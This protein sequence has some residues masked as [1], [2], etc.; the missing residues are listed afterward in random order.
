MLGPSSGV[1]FGSWFGSRVNLSIKKRRKRRNSSRYFKRFADQ[2]ISSGWNC[3]PGAW[4]NGICESGGFLCLWLA[5]WAEFLDGF[6]LRNF[7][8]GNEAMGFFHGSKGVGFYV[9]NSR[10]DFDRCSGSGVRC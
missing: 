5:L 1:A 4:T 9:S 8:H 2:V 3:L 6:P 10:A 7:A